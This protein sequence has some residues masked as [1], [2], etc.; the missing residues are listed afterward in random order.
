MPVLYFPTPQRS[1][2]DRYCDQALC[3]AVGLA[4]VQL[5][6]GNAF[7]NTQC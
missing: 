6:M 1:S 3:S 7:V 4:T 5:K 2:E